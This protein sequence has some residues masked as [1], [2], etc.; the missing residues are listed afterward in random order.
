MADAYITDFFSLEW[1]AVLP[2]CTLGLFCIGF[3][4][5]RVINGD[6]PVFGRGGR[7]LFL[8]DFQSFAVHGWQ[9]PL[10]IGEKILEFLIISVNGFCHCLKGVSLVVLEQS[11]NGKQK[12][13]HLFFAK[14]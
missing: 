8:N 7:A 10:R 13:S 4:A 3:W 1:A 2:F 5:S 12:Q 9:I 14:A 11:I 6:K